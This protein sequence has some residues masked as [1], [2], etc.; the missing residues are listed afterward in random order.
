MSDDI[1]DIEAL[2]YNVDN[3]L[4]NIVYYLNIYRD[5]ETLDYNEIKRCVDKIKKIVEN[6]REF[7]RHFQNPEINFL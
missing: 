5:L 4:K 1:R 7:R 3:N 2:K 6:Q